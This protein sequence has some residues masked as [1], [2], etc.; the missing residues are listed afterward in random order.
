MYQ[1]NK[2]IDI[3]RKDG[4]LALAREFI[5]YILKI[6][7]NIYIP[8]CYWRIRNRAFRGDPN[9]LVDFAFNRCNGLIKPL[10]SQYEILELLVIL[11]KVKPRFILE[12]GTADGGTLFLFSRIAFESACI[13]SI[14][15]PHGSCGNGY[16]RWKIPFY[17]S[18]CLPN[19]KMHLIRGDSHHSI[20][21]DMVKNVLGPEM[22]DFL[23]LDGDHTYEG[24]KK[25]FEMYNPLVKK[26]GII[27]I[28]DIMPTLKY[29]NYRVSTYWN[30]I[31]SKY[32]YAEIVEDCDQD[33][34]GIGLIK[35]A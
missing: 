11:N 19:Q 20:S 3:L 21:F 25:D 26:G 35:K 6:K 33:W 9:Q 8:Y 5:H 23:F 29:D 18:F 24:I 22:L 13:V 2:A 34:R 28:H 1:L 15:L 14:D 27:A 7:K 10:Q 4:P 17:K 30:E 31:K 32:E 16:P 12:I